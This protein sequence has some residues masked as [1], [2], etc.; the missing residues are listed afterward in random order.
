MLLLFSEDY[1]I[2]YFLRIAILLLLE[3]YHYES[4]VFWAIIT[5]NGLIHLKMLKEVLLELSSRSLI[6]WQ[7][8]INKKIFEE[9]MLLIS[10][11]RLL[12]QTFVEFCACFLWDI[13][14]IAWCFGPLQCLRDVL[15]I[16]IWIFHIFDNNVEIMKD[17]AKYLTESCWSDLHFSFNNFSKSSLTDFLKIIRLFVAAVC[18]NGSNMTF[19]WVPY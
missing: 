7:I 6:I 15:D 13:N 14:K 19:L 17:F 1:F 9:K 8:I 4:Q 18:I 2:K 10:F 11:W 12:H 3:W 5:M 16:V